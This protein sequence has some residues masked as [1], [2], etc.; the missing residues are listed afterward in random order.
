MSLNVEI[1]WSWEQF[2]ILGASKF[3]RTERFQGDLNLV[4][5]Q[6]E[7]AE[8]WDFTSR[9]QVSGNKEL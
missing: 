1:F 3:R 8:D 6:K 5:K 2:G 9:T 4:I 7:K